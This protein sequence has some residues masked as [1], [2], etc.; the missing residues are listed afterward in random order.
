MS[1]K[2]KYLDEL[3]QIMTEN[4]GM[5]RPE[6]VIEYAKDPT[7][8]LHDAFTWD[9]SIAANAWR[10][11]QARQL[12]RVSME[13]LPMDPPTKYKVFL[14]L[15]EDRYNDRGYRAMVDVLAD[16]DL[17]QVMLS[18]AIMDMETFMQKYDTL[19]ELAGV[20]A[21]M[22]KVIKKKSVARKRKY[23]QVQATA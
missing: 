6:D 20:F 18:E 15:K 13:F 23:K 10:K 19:K 17:R 22:Q 2:A 3:K 14:S 4:G 21:E 12:I 16:G 9:D 1:K 8:N 5:L 11:H 7:T